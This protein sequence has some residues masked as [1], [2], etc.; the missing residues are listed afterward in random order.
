[1]AL[2]ITHPDYMLEPHWR[3]VYGRFLAAFNDD[4]TVW[5]ALPREVSAWWRRRA[6]SEIVRDGD[7]WRVTGPAAVEA[8][9]ALAEP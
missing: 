4:P 7:G 5:Q 2:L 3:A 1:M 8:R 6:E 9:V